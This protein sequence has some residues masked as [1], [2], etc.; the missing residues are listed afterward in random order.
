MYV[1]VPK[2]GPVV[3]F[4]MP[5]SVKSWVTATKSLVAGIV[6]SF[7]SKFEFDMLFKT[8][9]STVRVPGLFPGER[10]PPF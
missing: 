1:P 4:M 6:T 10:M 9:E 8:K 3:R 7:N 5:A 2:S